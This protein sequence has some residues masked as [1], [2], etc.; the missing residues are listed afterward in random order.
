MMVVLLVPLLLL[1]LQVP[2]SEMLPHPDGASTC[3][4]ALLLSPHPPLRL[5]GRRGL[6]GSWRRT[7]RMRLRWKDRSALVGS[8]TKGSPPCWQNASSSALRKS[9]RGRTRVTGP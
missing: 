5:S 4:P 9:S 1:L 2:F 6:G 7:W 8:V 3:L